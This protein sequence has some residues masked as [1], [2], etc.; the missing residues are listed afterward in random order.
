MNTLTL[1]WQRTNQDHLAAVAERARARVEALLGSHLELEQALA[2]LEEA[3]QQCPAPPAFELLAQ[4]FQLGTFEQEALG[5]VAAHELLPNFA[6]RCAVAMG[7]EFAA[8]PTPALALAALPEASWHVFAPEAPLRKFRLLE[9]EP[10]PSFA[11][12]GLRMPERVLH[13][14][15]GVHTLDAGGVPVQPFRST[16]DLTPGQADLAERIADRWRKREGGRLTPFWIAGPDSRS[17][18]GYT[19]GILRLQTYAASSEA[20]LSEG[21]VDLWTREALLL[22]AGL[23]IECGEHD[24][25]R[26]C[27]L[28]EEIEFPALVVSAMP[29]T[30]ASV[31]VFECPQS[32]AGE[33]ADLWR[34][35]LG[36]KG[37]KLNGE[38]DTVARQFRLTPDQ[39]AVAASA[40]DPSED[41]EAALWREGRRAARQRLDGLTQRIDTRAAWDD[42][43]LPDAP[44]AMLKEI[45]AHVKHR[46]TVYDRWGFAERT[47]RGL[48]LAAL[49]AGPS[50]TGK[51]LAAEVL[52]NELRLDLHQVDLSRIVSKYIGETEKN[53]RAVFDAA[54]GSGAILLFDEADALFGKRTEVRDSHDRYANLEVSYLLQLTENYEGL[55]ILT[56]NLKQA[57]DPAFLRRLR[58]TV[59]FPFPD[60][61][62]RSEIWKRAFPAAAPLG[63]IDFDKLSEWSIS[64][65]SI[66]NVA[67]NAAFAA[68]EE[69]KPLEM[70][71]LLRAAR[72]EF[73]KLERPGA[74][75][76]G[77]R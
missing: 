64:G 77:L 73:A 38:V 39:I 66:R 57:I 63:K 51:T 53:L 47:S 41:A 28:L 26:L 43:I 9:L 40:V 15:M 14:L 71:H 49:F 44:K 33:R 61:V 62:Q 67:L 37:A 55:V 12:S 76:E 23:I 24:A 65:G 2:V 3:R 30:Q 50:G 32:T 13:Y 29:P 5:L 68:A 8:Y 74:E 27:R 59:S 21:F 16:T 45:A 35:S 17:L 6:A 72:A 20:A 42:L 19:A 52:A 69:D 31:P 25:P 18:A 70:D 56:S 36:E 22:G 54:E 34:R 10:G 11:L 48:G 46:A 4:S 60:L 75:L 58:F 7:S 1:D